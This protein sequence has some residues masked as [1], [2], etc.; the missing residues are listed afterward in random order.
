MEKLINKSF[1][2]LV[3]LSTYTFVFFIFISFVTV[4]FALDAKHIILMIADGRGPQHNAAKNDYTGTIPAYQSDPQW[5]P[6]WMS[7]FPYGGSY[8]ATQAWTNFSYVTTGAT[9]SAAS[10]SAIY[11]GNKTNIGRVSVSPDGSERFYTIGE[12]A[13]SLGKGTGVVT[14]VPISDATPGVFC[15]HNLSRANTYAIVDECLFGD[16]N[17]TGTIA[18]DPKYGGG[19]GSTFPTIDVIIGDG[20]YGYVND[21]IRNKL[22]LENGQPGKHVFVKRETGVDGGAALWAAANN[23]ATTKLAGLFDHIYRHDPSYSTENPTLAESTRAALAVLQKNPKGFVLVVEG[24]A[25]DWASHSN[26]M[27][28]MIGEMIDFDEAVD[29]VID[30][31]NTNDPAWANTLVIVTSDHETG[32]LTSRPGIFQD[33]PLGEVSDTTL[34]LEK[35]ITNSGGRRASWVDADSDSIVDP[36]ELVYWAWNSGVHTN[37]LVPL[38]TRGVG[39][40]LFDWYATSYDPVR[41]LYLDNTNIFSVMATIVGNQPPFAQ[42]DL[43]GTLQ[44]TPVTINVIANDTDSDGTID[45]ATV[46]ITGAAGYG[47]ATANSNGTVI[48]TPNTG[49]TGTDS[50]RYTVKDNGGAISNEATVTIKVRPVNEVF[51]AYNDLSWSSGQVSTN[52]TTYTTGQ[53]GVLKDY[54]TGTDTT[55]TLAITGGYVNAITRTQGS[56]ANIGTDA[57]T[58]FNGIVDSLGLISYVIANLTFTFSNLDPSMSYELVLFGNRNN[59]SYTDRFTTI[60]LSDVD[61]FINASTPGTD[62]TGP[63][64]PSVT[65]MNGY[66]TTNGYVGRFININPGI[67]GTMLVTVSSSDGR[68]YMNALMLKALQQPTNQKPTATDDVATAIR[69]TPVT[70]DVIANDKDADG[71]IDPATITITSGPGNGSVFPNTNGTVTYKP[72]IGFT[73]TDSFTY[74][75]KDNDGATSNEATVTVTV[76]F[77]EINIKEGTIGTEIKIT[78]NAFGNKKGKVFI[79]NK[80]TKILRDQWSQETIICT[81]TRVPRAESYPATFDLRIKLQP[82]L[83]IKDAITLPNVFTIKNP[84]I[85]NVSSNSG[86]PGTPVFITGKFFGKRKPRVY[87]E[88]TDSKG[89]F[90]K[91][92]CRVASWTMNPET[93]EGTIE[94]LVPETPERHVAGSSYRLKVR[95]RVGTTGEVIYFTIDSS[96]YSL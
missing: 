83:Q 38:Y 84:E 59:E 73:G 8:D 67:D 16:P 13:K 76:I 53:S 7:T 25:I 12:K 95:N 34:D 21:A 44:S 62:F 93:N 65:I 19:L 24:G 94:F 29:A 85:D 31:V 81:L 50:F 28:L 90:R 45:P 78:G 56:G 96:S 60:T 66:N 69:D 87:L 49:F 52:I 17:T 47:T 71:T 14:T 40:E 75:V 3:Y 10:A 30:W 5:I 36:S 86:A 92:Y 26:N 33:Q 68:F 58:V 82:Y 27:D 74:T 80:A 55:V 54:I 64:D 61:S 22:T 42:D 72:A 79:G 39:A 11:S 51:V 63:N 32:Y 37:T 23:P 1:R 88:Y 89:K 46:T 48:Y 41:G 6:Y 91:K 9:D 18:N 4:G 20:R 2:S 35:I 15:A 57:Y 77:A 70:V 43:G